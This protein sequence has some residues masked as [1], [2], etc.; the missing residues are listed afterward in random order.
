MK[1]WLVKQVGAWALK[2]AVGLLSEKKRARELRAMSTPELLRHAEQG[3]VQAR[4]V[5]PELNARLLGKMG[6]VE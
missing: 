2:V 5:L 4:E 6:D 3:E 1:T